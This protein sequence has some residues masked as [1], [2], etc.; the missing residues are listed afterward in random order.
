VI[1]NFVKGSGGGSGPLTAPPVL[2]TAKEGDLATLR[3][4][5]DLGSESPLKPEPAILR[6][7]TA[8][9]LA[10]RQGLRAITVVGQGET[11]SE[12]GLDV[13]E[14]VFSEGHES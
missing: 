8:A 3:M 9:L 1:I 6:R 11:A 10:R 12:A 2:L 14:K 5:V 7:T 4:N 13:I